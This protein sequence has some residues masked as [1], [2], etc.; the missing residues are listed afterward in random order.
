MASLRR[1]AAADAATGGR[2]GSTAPTG[3]G[4]NR[5]WV[6]RPYGPRKA[7]LERR[8]KQAGFQ[9]GSRRGRIAGDVSRGVGS[10]GSMAAT[11]ALV[12][13]EKSHLSLTEPSSSQRIFP[14]RE[15]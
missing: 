13:L 6:F 2:D 12:R 10:A 3:E 7:P 15:R 14:C 5:E 9:A 4:P 1:M 8:L 11:A